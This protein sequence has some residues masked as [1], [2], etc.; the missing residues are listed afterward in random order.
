MLLMR[1]APEFFSR[2]TLE[3]AK[4]V[5]LSPAGD[6]TTAHRWNSET[7]WLMQRIEFDDDRGLVIDYGCGI[8][9]LAKLIQNPVLGID[10]SAAMRRYACDYVGRT[11]FSA[12]AP[13]M[14]ETLVRSGLRANALVAVW[15]LQHIWDID[16][17]I[18]LVMRAMRPGAPIWI[19]DLWERHV[20]GF[21]D[22][23][24]FVMFN[25]GAD[26]LSLLKPWCNLESS[27][28]LTLPHRGDGG[29]PACLK[30]FRR[31][32]AI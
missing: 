20:P 19:L 12:V 27:E 31:K 2:A 10:V 6:V 9:R 26:L 11:Q 1:Y 16:S 28:T 8:G 13:G 32:A 4:G 30:K 24:K 5:I 21:D 15:A 14:F 17:T 23:N 18:K 7:R 22:D 3:E 25:D 29:L